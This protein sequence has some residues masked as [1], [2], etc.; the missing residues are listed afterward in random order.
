MAKSTGGCNFL[1]VFIYSFIYLKEHK[2]Q[3]TTLELISTYSR[4]FGYFEKGITRL[5][6]KQTPDQSKDKSYNNKFRL[7]L[8]IIK[9]Y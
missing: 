5:H 7:V 8:I 6:D 1:N 4:I 2:K 3:S 9:K